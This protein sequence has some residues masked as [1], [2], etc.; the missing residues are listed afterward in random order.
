MFNR[1]Y[2]I[3]SPGALLALLCFFLPWVLVSCGGQPVAEFSGWELASGAP[4]QTAF[5][6]QEMEATPLFFAVP[7]GALA[8]LGLALAASR[9]AD[10]TTLDVIGPLLAGVLPLAVLLLRY[11]NARDE[12]LSSGLE[13][14]LR[15]GLWGVLAGLLAIAAGAVVNRSS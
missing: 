1:G 11:M 8:A 15:F 5:G 2:A 6:P 3:T 13:V 14:S 7:V 12:M 4:V 9:R 10:M